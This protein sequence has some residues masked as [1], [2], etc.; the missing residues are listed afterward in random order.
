MQLS[1]AKGKKKNL[2][3][4]TTTRNGV[5]TKS[6]TL[7]ISVKIE[8]YSFDS[9]RKLGLLDDYEFADSTRRGSETDIR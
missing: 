2:L 5:Y 6:L 7:T 3:G 1:G 4:T 9:L 8:N